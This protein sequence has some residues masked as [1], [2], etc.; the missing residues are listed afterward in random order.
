MLLFLLFSLYAKA[1]D[2]PPVIARPK[3]SIAKLSPRKGEDFP[4]IL[5]A[6]A[7][8]LLWKPYELG[9]LGEGPGTKHPQPL[10]RTDAF[11][12]TTFIETVMAN[13]Y[14]FGAKN[15]L[16]KKMRAIRYKGGKIGFRER[17]HI[18]ELDWLPNNVRAGYLEDL[19]G[20]LFPGE[21]KTA[22]V[23]INREEWLASQGEEK[24]PA[25]QA[26]AKFPYLPAAVFFRKREGKPP[27]PVKKP[28]EEEELD[29]VKKKFRAEL[30]ALRENYEPIE[31]KLREIP[32]GTILNLVSAEKKD[33]LLPAIT[34]QGL[35]VQREDGAHFLHAAKANG[36][37]SDARLG[38][39]LL[40]YMKSANYRGIS[41]YRILP[42][43][44]K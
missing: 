12:C 40:R 35:V 13:A 3:P 9:P 11:D 29:P 30:A 37:V 15:C 2:F 36:H 16:E 10:Y 25:M 5:D 31:E 21:W 20:K 44:G 43:R 18:P 33:P 7:R 6:V 14:C 39:Y 22:N 42:A 1:E 19:S 8:A 17:N 32:S 41:L 38:D 28:E 4:L 24:K 23:T 34:H 26:P 27:E